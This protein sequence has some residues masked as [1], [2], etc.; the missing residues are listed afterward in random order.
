MKT[1]I[2]AITAILIIVAIAASAACGAG[3]VFLSPSAYSK[4]D[5]VSTARGDWYLASGNPVANEMLEQE[6]TATTCSYTI[7]WEEPVRLTN[8]DSYNRHPKTVI[9]GANIY[10]TWRK[11]GEGEDD[12]YFMMSPDKGDSWQYVCKLSETSETASNYRQTI[13]GD[14]SSV[15]VAWLHTIRG[16]HYRKSISGGQSWFDIEH[17]GWDTAAPALC[18]LH[19]DSVF[20]FYGSIQAYWVTVSRNFGGDWGEALELGVFRPSGTYP[21]SGVS[22]NGIHV[23]GQTSV[24][25]E[26]PE[27]FYDGSPDRGNTWTT[28][29][30]LTVDD[31]IPSQWPALGAD[32]SGR[33]Y[34][35]WF[36]YKYS[37]GCYGDLLMRRSMDDGVTWEDEQI[38]CF[39]HLVKRSTI[40]ANELGVFVAWEDA[41]HNPGYDTD[42]YV[43]A[44]YDYGESWQDE[45][46]LT[47]GS[48]DSYDPC[49]L[50]DGTDLHLFWSDN[51]E[52][53]IGLN[54]IY[55]RRGHLVQTGVTTEGA[56]MPLQ[57]R[58]NISPNPFNVTTM[59]E[60]SVQHG[61]G[62]LKSKATKTKLEVYNILG[63]K[64]ETLVN[65]YQQNGKYIANWNARDYRSGVYLVYLTNGHHA[66]SR[67][68]VLLK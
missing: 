59:I 48:S 32:S 14:A 23:T 68:A 22:H 31:S 24:I 11:I 8:N 7:E 21:G 61:N 13:V 36:D 43:Q 17:F 3:A 6:K 37:G 51:S 5:T 63:R 35:T 40:A 1:V 16:I 67:K 55:Y 33:V 41:R 25:T 45:E 47:S 4:T 39:S 27:V 20:L 54:E 53:T 64:V 57:L 62:L 42:I 56:E 50:I 65:E 58:L 46:R 2:T 29:L 52:D 44:S 66:I 9:S 38:I 15:L 28:D 10:L 60:Y 12:V 18:K 19:P 34:V 30:L 49:L 26:A